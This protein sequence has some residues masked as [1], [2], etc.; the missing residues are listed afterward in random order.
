MHQ[1]LKKKKKNSRPTDPTWEVSP[2]VKQFFFSSPY[3]IFFFLS[4]FFIYPSLYQCAHF[5]YFYKVIISFLLKLNTVI[6]G[7]FSDSNAYFFKEKL[8]PKISVQSNSTFSSCARCMCV[9]L[10]LSETFY[11]KF[12][13]A[14]ISYW[15]DFSLIPL[16]KC[17]Y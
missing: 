10:S 7:I 6:Q 1:K 8:I 11:L 3:A 9:E 15:N 16:K 14:L 4:F 17:G 2:P 13:M 5:G 12:E